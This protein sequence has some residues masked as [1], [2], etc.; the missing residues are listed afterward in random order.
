MSE[1]IIEVKDLS[2]AYHYQSDKS[3]QTEWILKDLSFHLHAG[4]MLGIMG[5]N[6]GGKSTLLALLM[7]ERRALK[8]EISFFGKSIHSREHLKEIS[9]LAQ[10]DQS[11]GFFPLTVESILDFAGFKNPSFHGQKDQVLRDLDLV[12][13]RHSLYRELSGGQKQ[14]TL[15]AK[16]FLENPRVL[17]LDEPTKGLDAKG[18]DQLLS[19]I[20]HWSQGAEAKKRCAIIVDH[21][22]SHLLAHCD[23]IMCLNRQAH[24]HDS[25]DKFSKDIFNNVYHCEYEHLL[26]HEKGGHSCS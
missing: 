18:Q 13:L 6:G 16:A 24:W 4:S 11:A 19:L 9:Y 14:R 7:G 20:R 8:G 12:E 22:I 3:A 17:I 15:L 1:A 21:N 5:P 2:F 23:R 10:E 26:L 25:K